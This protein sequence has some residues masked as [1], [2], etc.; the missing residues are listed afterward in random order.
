[1]SRWANRG[2]ERNIIQEIGGRCSQAEERRRC[3]NKK[4]LVGDPGAHFLLG[5][6]DVYVQTNGAIIDARSREYY[7]YGQDEWKV[8]PDLTVTFGAGWDIETP[9][10]NLYYN[11]KD[12]N[13][14]RQGQ[15]STVFPN[16]P[17]GVLWPGDAGINSAGGVR[18]PWHDLAPRLGFACRPG[19]SKTGASTLASAYT[20][21]E[22]RKNWPCKTS[23]R[24][25][26]LWPR[27][28][29]DCMRQAG[30]SGHRGLAGLPTLVALLD[31]VTAPGS[32]ARPSDELLLVRAIEV[33]AEMGPAARAAVPSLKRA[34]TFSLTAFH[35]ANEALSALNEEQ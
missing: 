4:L 18:T 16:A 10:L 23:R 17:T 7:F 32:R 13:A 22:R 11:G 35:A 25:R 12:V 24:S 15:Q 20:T 28:G 30:R 5:Q 6:P 34:R 31:S 9:Y 33:I 1:M 8:R 3:A 27:C 2:S 26:E 19:G 29:G 14:F 21:T